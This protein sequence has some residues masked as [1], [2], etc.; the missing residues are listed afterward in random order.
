MI[1][2]GSIRIT[3]IIPVICEKLHLKNPEVFSLKRIVDGKREWM[4]PSQSLDEQGIQRGEPVFFRKRLYS[5]EK[6]IDTTD[7]IQLHL[8]FAQCVETFLSSELPCTESD[9]IDLASLLLQI[10]YG[11][12]NSGFKKHDWSKCLPKRFSRVKNI[13]KKILTAY[14]N[15]K[16]TRSILGK[17]KFA[18]LC[19]GLSHYGVN[20]FRC[21]L[22]GKK[23]REALLGVSSEKVLL[24]DYESFD[25]YHSYEFKELKQ[26][27]AN[28]DILSLNFG[29][30]EEKEISISTKDASVIVH[31]IR[32]YIDCIVKN[33]TQ[34]KPS[35]SADEELFKE[36][37]SQVIPYSNTHDPTVVNV[38]KKKISFHY[39]VPLL[40]NGKDVFVN[41]ITIVQIMREH[42][43]NQ[44]NDF[45]TGTIE[46]CAYLDNHN[47]TYILSSLIAS[48]SNVEYIYEVIRSKK[49]ADKESIVDMV[50]KDI[51]KI[52]SGIYNATSSGDPYSRKLHTTGTRLND[53]LVSLL[54]S[55]SK[56]Y[57]F[58]DIENEAIICK[59]IRRVEKFKAQLESFKA[60][61]SSRMTSKTVESLLRNLAYMMFSNLLHIEEFAMT[62]PMK[63]NNESLEALKD[64]KEQI[65][66]LSHLLRTQGQ[67]ILTE[68]IIEEMADYNQ[69]IKRKAT[70]SVSNVDT[71][72]EPFHDFLMYSTELEYLISNLSVHYDSDQSEDIITM[73][74]DLD[75]FFPKILDDFGNAH[76][77]SQI[78]SISLM[79][80][81]LITMSS[82]LQIDDS[83]IELKI[84]NCELK[85]KNLLSS[86]NQV[87]DGTMIVKCFEN[88]TRN[89]VRQLQYTTIRLASYIGSERNMKTLRIFTIQ[90]TSSITKMNVF[91][92]DNISKIEDSI[93]MEN[94]KSLQRDIGMF[95]KRTLRTFSYNNKKNNTN[96]L[97]G[98]FTF[99]EFKRYQ[100]LVN[101]LV[102]SV[103]CIRNSFDVGDLFIFNEIKAQIKKSLD[104]MKTSSLMFENAVRIEEGFASLDALDEL[105]D[106][107]EDCLRKHSRKDVRMGIQYQ[108]KLLESLTVLRQYSTDLTKSLEFVSG[109]SILPVATLTV[110]MTEIIPL[111][112]KRAQESLNGKTLLE[113]SLSMIHHIQKS[114]EESVE[115][116]DD[117]SYS[118]ILK[119]SLHH[120]LMFQCVYHSVGILEGGQYGGRNVTEDV[121]LFVRLF[122]MVIRQ[123]QH[124]TESDR[125]LGDIETHLEAM[126]ILD[127]LYLCHNNSDLL[128]IA[129]RSQ[130]LVLLMLDFLYSL[131][132]LSHTL[133]FEQE[134]RPLIQHT[135]KVLDCVRK[136]EPI[137]NEFDR[138]YEHINSIKSIL[139]SKYQ[140]NE[141]I[142]RELKN[143]SKVVYN[144]KHLTTDSLSGSQ[145]PKGIRYHCNKIRMVID[146]INASAYRSKSVLELC[147]SLKELAKISITRLTQGE[148]LST[149]HLV[150]LTLHS[151]ST[152]YYYQKNEITEKLTTLKS[153]FQ[154]L[155]ELASANTYV[156]MDEK[157][158]KKMDE[159]IISLSQVEASFK[160]ALEFDVDVLKD[161]NEMDP[162]KSKAK[163]EATLLLKELHQKAKELNDL[164]KQFI[165]LCF[166]E[167]KYALRAHE[168][169]ELLA[170]SIAEYISNLE[171]R[172]VSKHMKLTESIR[173]HVDDILD[174]EIEIISTKGI[175]H[176]LTVNQVCTAISDLECALIET[177]TSVLNDVSSE[178]CLEKLMVIIN[179]FKDIITGEEDVFVLREKM[180]PLICHFSENLIGFSRDLENRD[181][182]IL[183]GS[184][185]VF[186]FKDMND[187][188]VKN[189]DN[190]MLKRS[191]TNEKLSE[192]TSTDDN[193]N[194]EV[195][196]KDIAHVPKTNTTPDAGI[197]N[198]SIKSLK[199]TK[200]AML[201]SLNDLSVSLHD[202]GSNQKEKLLEELQELVKYSL[203]YPVNELKSIQI[204]VET[205]DVLVRY[206]RKLLI[207]LHRAIDDGFNNN[208]HYRKV[209]IE[210]IQKVLDILRDTTDNRNWKRTSKAYSSILK[211]IIEVV[212]EQ[213]FGTSLP[214]KLKELL[215]KYKCIAYNIKTPKRRRKPR[216]SQQSSTDT[217]ST[218]GTESV[219][220]ADENT[221]SL[222]PTPSTSSEDVSIK[223]NNAPT[224]PKGFV[225]DVLDPSKSLADLVSSFSKDIAVGVTNLVEISLEL[226]KEIG[227]NFKKTNRPYLEDPSWDKGYISSGLGVAAAVTLLV[228]Y[229][230]AT[231]K[232]E[233]DEDHFLA[234]SKTVRAATTQLVVVSRVKAPSGSEIMMKLDKASKY[235]SDITETLAQRIKQSY[236][237]DLRTANKDTKAP[238][239]AKTSLVKKVGE[240]DK[241]SEIARLEQ[242]LLEARQNLLEWRKSRYKESI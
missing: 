234:A 197:D 155:I 9:A 168:S 149:Y 170:I 102:S 12:H 49:F 127:D 229:A 72:F 184:N 226:Q 31:V 190:I 44:L 185:F 35:M 66:S 209:I 218:L 129:N 215:S 172:N 109:K 227:S 99:Q 225:P 158:R 114:I 103:Q 53:S 143:I 67:F 241:K 30:A 47:R 188:K 119:E 212:E 110:H 65:Q 176:L 233:I 27:H 201:K 46:K 202:S 59:S 146:S 8:L 181:A 69:E 81:R 162:V 4:I 17:Y 165:S 138:F 78:S 177:N 60:I 90:G 104:Y 74:V 208:S 55:L 43:K 50:L 238:I 147:Q 21:T 173:T 171:K 126:H 240:F 89:I 210:C 216:L 219:S 135:D 220:D 137:D 5:P 61:V 19:R 189:M 48:L 113:L 154:K 75:G 178:Q 217:I 139:Y 124:F 11:D 136:N 205:Y 16:G 223:E 73:C 121:Q 196:S 123:P 116:S 26:F 206:S 25:V 92:S 84:R 98:E 83:R 80:D 192:P 52:N 85:I 207:T 175:H 232:G 39:N 174:K 29:G 122:P 37:T 3:D 231:L 230:N 88:V 140:N 141:D 160:K 235:I 125:I 134:Y 10:E 142:A 131:S 203:K 198:G 95:T 156:V 82:Q 22:L 87:L 148:V 164:T 150:R 1:V 213:S 187:G 15:L 199:E 161:Y 182:I 63:F 105:K 34:L 224:T 56:I 14:K 191:T 107:V 157:V 239:G 169:I 211:Y 236:S 76:T 91:L 101:N 96:S 115:T 145:K 79:I 23:S 117:K 144:M 2:D 183:A 118:E 194:A 38:T 42:L 94:I 128:G 108:E 54:K 186:L 193:S 45:M 222:E 58:D 204:N 51:A 200:E 70:I 214:S 97:R 28:N 64:T 112:C 36:L 195:D 163:I 41:A 57:Q 93:E 33:K 77:K 18:Q 151:L 40:K 32:Q 167:Y 153:S 133:D 179:K 62:N 132:A 13:E 120:L 228:K 106:K 7:S 20:Y 6:D 111:L 71:A 166:P 242:E 130:R 86:L 24:L 237:T 68:R 152:V 100:N 159:C 180:N 221:L